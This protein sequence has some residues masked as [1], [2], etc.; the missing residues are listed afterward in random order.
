MIR[1]DDFPLWEVQRKKIWGRPKIKAMLNIFKENF[2]WK[3]ISKKGK[4]IMFIFLE[5]KNNFK[6]KKHNL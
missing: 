6:E 5:T 2:F 3:Q 1:K 4:A